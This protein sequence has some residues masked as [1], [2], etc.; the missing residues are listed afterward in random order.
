MQC[1]QSRAPVSA[2]R[3]ADA[4]GRTT[5]PKVRR[6]RELRCSKGCLCNKLISKSPTRPAS[7]CS[8]RCMHPKWLRSMPHCLAQQ[9]LKCRAHFG[10]FK[11]VA[12]LLQRCRHNALPVKYNR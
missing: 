11:F 12:G 5:L 9:I 1:V 6:K 10:K 7:V 4:A 2:A 3:A 8:L